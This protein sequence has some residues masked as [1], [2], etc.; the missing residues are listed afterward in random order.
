[1]LVSVG[2]IPAPARV[3]YARFRLPKLGHAH[4]EP[5]ANTEDIPNDI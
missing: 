2:E 3:T 4:G 1:M 5:A